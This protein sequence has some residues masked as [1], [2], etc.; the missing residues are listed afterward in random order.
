MPET[1]LTFEDLEVLI[2][3]TMPR[4]QEDQQNEG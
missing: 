4:I 1:G 2:L 3:A